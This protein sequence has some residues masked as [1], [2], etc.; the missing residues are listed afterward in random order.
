MGAAP[1][2][3]EPF[4]AAVVQAAP[5]ALDVDA[6]LQRVAG[7]RPRRAGRRATGGLPRGVPR[8]LSQG[9][10]FGIRLGTRSDAGRAAFER[11]HAA[12][13]DVPGPAVDRLGAIAAEHGMEL[14]IGVVER[15]GGTLYC[16]A[17]FVGADGLRGSTALVPTALERC[18]WGRGDAS[19]LT[20]VDFR[21]R[22]SAAI[23]WEN[24]MPLLR[25][26]PTTAA[27]RSTAPPPWTTVRPGRPPCDT[28]QSKAAV[29][30]W[31]RVSLKGLRPPPRLAARTPTRASCSPRWERH[32]RSV[33][34]GPRRPGLRRGD[35]TVADIDPGVTVRGRFDL[36]VSG[37][38]ADRTCSS[39]ASWTGATTSRAERPRPTRLWPHAFDRPHTSLYA[40]GP[41]VC[42]RGSAQP[43]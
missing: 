40:I 24:Y 29:T 14:V 15:D 21:G 27:S 25:A 1:T 37:H 32:R 43:E 33:R 22:I 36:D 13:V 35:R 7:Y 20:V 34:R 2:P 4:R 3:P 10:D 31:P 17:L 38:Y 18:V 30:C 41:V 42:R 26:A 5:V 8:R 19:T 23:C 11:Y 39:C 9:V 6:T 16:T 28:W 12:A